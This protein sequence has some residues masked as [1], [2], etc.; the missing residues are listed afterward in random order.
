M[1]DPFA[2]PR[3]YATCANPEADLEAFFHPEPAHSKGYLFLALAA[4]EAPPDETINGSIHHLL[5]GLQ[6]SPPVIE[7]GARYLLSSQLEDGTWHV[8]RRAFP[9]QPTMHSGFP[10]GRDSWIS[11]TATSWAVMA[12]TLPEAP[13]A[14]ALQK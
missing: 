14:L 11:A 9:F 12:L 10:H 5:A 13:G 6:N 3:R 4:E 8:R 2:A 1:S 7:R